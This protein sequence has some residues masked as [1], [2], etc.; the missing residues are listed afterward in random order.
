MTLLEVE[1]LDV[2]YGDIQV[3]WDVS[4]RVGDEDSVVAIVGPNGAGK[5]TLMRALAGILAPTAGRVRL[6]GEETT[7]A[8]PWAI[9]SQGFVLVPEEKEL[10]GDMSVFENLK[11]GAYT[12][13]DAFDERLEEMF[14]MFP[15]LEERRDQRAGTLS[16]GEQ[17]MC[18]IARGLMAGPRLLA[19]DEPSGGLAPQLADQVFERIDAISDRM[20]VILVEQHVDRAL[21]LAD[22]AYLLENGRIAASGTGE[23]LLDSDHIAE[24]YLSTA[25]GT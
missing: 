19:L 16:G 12:D 21:E 5:T 1:D 23:E 10:F 2:G 4:V 14:R 3:L 13:R 24:A 15:R 6:F 25:S 11:M 7:G 20:P 9:V 17:Q 22:R 8:S 18:A